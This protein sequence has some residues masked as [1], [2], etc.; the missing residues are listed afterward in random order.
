MLRVKTVLQESTRRPVQGNVQ[1]AMLVNIKMKKASHH[2]K[3]ALLV[4]T[5]QLVWQIVRGVLLVNTRIRMVKRVVKDVVLDI[6]K[7]K[8]VRQS[9]K[10]VLTDITRVK[11]ERLHVQGVL[12]VILAIKKDRLHLTVVK[13]V[14]RVDIAA[15]LVQLVVHPVLA[16]NTRTKVGKQAAKV[17]LVYP[18]AFH[19]RIR[20]VMHIRHAHHPTKTGIK[21]VGC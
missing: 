4:S 18:V 10:I 16:Q 15:R 21:H 5:L 2:A 1:T 12:Q 13:V 17:A 8:V 7:T 19:A 20:A 9:V 3:I 6:G 14:L 11:M